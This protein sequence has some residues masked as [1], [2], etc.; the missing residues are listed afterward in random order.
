[1]R[2]TGS[3]LYKGWGELHSDVPRVEADTIRWVRSWILFRLAIIT[4]GIAARASLGQAS[5]ADAKA[6]SRVVFD[7][8]GK[9]AWESK[10]DAE[11]EAGQKGAK[12]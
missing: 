2:M 3:C 7:F 5:S 12:L 10:K 1:M 8:F 6:D 9:M 4:Q 11:K